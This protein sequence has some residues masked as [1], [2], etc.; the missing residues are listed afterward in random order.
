MTTARTC[1]WFTPEDAEKAID[2]YTSLIPETRV[3][4][5]TTFENADQ[6]DGQ[7][8][9]WT[10][11]IAGTPFQMM[12]SARPQGFTMAHSMW[13]V[14]DDQAEL[15][16]VWDGFL[17]A[18]GNELACGWIVDPFG[19][20][21]QVLPRVWEELTSGDQARAQRVAEALWGMVRIDVA[22]LEAAARG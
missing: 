10:L 17:A 3:V 9:V 18:G 19:L 6:P 8:R 2:L 11:Q 14:V 15:D 1:L 4:E 21:W 12:A 16:R 22:A 13:L 7:V 20:Q 5:T